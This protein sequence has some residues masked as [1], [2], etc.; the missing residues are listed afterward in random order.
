MSR[1]TTK[2]GAPRRAE[3]SRRERVGLWLHRE[4]DNRLSSLG[5]WAYRKTKGRIARP[6]DVD[7]LVL[8]TRGRRTGKERTVLL[9][10][11]Q[12][13]DGMVLAAAN[14]GSDSHPGWY[15][16]LTATSS[17]TIELGGR[18]IPVVA[19]EMGEA[20]AA[21]WWERIVRKD[22]AYQRYARATG[23]RIPILSL[24]PVGP[25]S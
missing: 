20:E 15:Y 17:A 16:N 6:W 14:G 24:T 10:Y 11:F 18:R 23:R 3:S 9:Q 22:P 12:D 1:Q 25:E 2:P 5:V 8:T 21:V 19:T 4:L 7:V 13:G